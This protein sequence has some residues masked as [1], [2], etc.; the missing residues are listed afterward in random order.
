MSFWGRIWVRLEIVGYECQVSQPSKTLWSLNIQCPWSCQETGET[1]TSQQTQRQFNSKI[2]NTRQSN[3]LLDSSV[4]EFHT[5]TL[6]H[7]ASQ[8]QSARVYSQAATLPNR[9]NLGQ[10]QQLR[11]KIIQ[12]SPN[13][14]QNMH[15]NRML[16]AVCFFHNCSEINVLFP[17]ATQREWRSRCK[18][19]TWWTHNTQSYCLQTWIIDQNEGPTCVPFR[20]V[21]SL[22]NEFQNMILIMTLEER[23]LPEM[24]ASNY[25]GT[26]W[27]ENQT[28]KPFPQQ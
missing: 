10:K 28:Q 23:V 26:R 9:K 19:S 8:T 2:Q 18:L 13:Y 14:D 16:R 17:T 27:K 6:L 21:D 20:A 3:Q 1:F 7:V 5:E 11:K 22:W 15:L 25:N 24:V 12:L 4:L